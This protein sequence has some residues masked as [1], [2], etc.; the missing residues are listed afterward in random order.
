[1]NNSRLLVLI[2]ILIVYGS[3]YPFNFSMAKP[4]ALVHLFSD[5]NLFTSM[6][7]MLG[8]V[9]LFAPLGLIAMLHRM[10]A[11]GVFRA[12]T[13][14]AVVGLAIA[15][16]LQVLQ[17]FL[18]TR[19]AALADV[20]WNMLGML[21]GALAGGHIA[22][23]S[24]GLAAL[25]RTRAMPA[26]L[27]VGLIA[28]EW[29]PL[30]PS[31]E[32]QLMR[33]Q[34]KLLWSTPITLGV[35]FWQGVAVA[36]FAGHLT[37]CVFN[38]RQSVVW[39]VLI[40]AAII[41]GKLF[42]E[43]MPIQPS[44]PVG[45]ALGGLVWVITQQG[46]EVRRRTLVWLTLILCY[47]ASA[48]APYQLRDA[49]ATISWLP[50]AAMLEGSILS[51]VRSLTSNLV[52]YVGIL[53]VGAKAGGQLTSATL[54]LALWTLV[55]EL[56]QTI[57][58]G[59]SAD[60]T[61]PIL[62]LLTGLAL[63]RFNQ[64]GPGFIKASDSAVSIAQTKRPT[65]FNVWP[66]QAGGAVIFLILALTVL[67]SLPA[68]PYNVR[69]LFRADAN[70]LALLAFSMA[71]LWTGGG[72]VWL[73]TRVARA[74]WP[75]L[76][77]VPLT[78]LVCGVSLALLWAGV[79]TESI[80]DISGSSNRFW[81]VTQREVWGSIWKAA[82]LWMDSPR[83][84]GNLEHFVRYSALYA[85]LPIVLGLLIALRQA[86]WRGEKRL[87]HL[88]GLLLSAGA[89]LWLCKAI[90][91]DWTSTDNLNELIARDGAWGWGGGGFIYALLLVV[92]INGLLLAEAA[93]AGPAQIS[94]A[95]LFSVAALPVGW[96][97]LNEGLEQNVQKYGL[98]YSGTQFLLGQ[99]RS[100]LLDPTEL[101]LRWC[102]TQVSAALVLST[103]V[104]L[105]QSACQKNLTQRLPWQHASSTHKKA[106]ECTPAI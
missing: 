10:P 6:G 38:R 104:W 79:N 59:R 11:W 42:I 27:L 47:T 14:I 96:W 41:A 53:Y 92:C 16:G 75:G 29:L 19:D 2:T 18:P 40:L 87:L 24:F 63:A 54:G 12:S 31:L 62:V 60:I 36:M 101:F 28:V 5:R 99:D 43:D 69:E 22:T 89:L 70:P 46:A 94:L 4:G 74:R 77:L 50:F 20:A 88:T 7:D 67:L 26:Y 8:N 81:F 105:G 15:L 37:A 71:L 76:Q 103:G 21:I 39:L 83:W 3:L 13:S 78:L 80:E 9:F 91:F 34:L 48:L 45:L 23:H 84:I 66:L 73:G 102:A 25:P 57:I 35:P 100:N 97:L 65:G 44:G 1:M 51:N 64:P 55:M 72:A 61:E 17:I 86:D 82:F 30:V 98:V 85:P 93:S 90:A 56:M 68:I 49:A 52:F 95:M 58:K 32:L 33:A 106:T